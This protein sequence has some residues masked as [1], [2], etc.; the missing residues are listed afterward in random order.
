MVS[1]ET[2]KA[3]LLD[4]RGRNVLRPISAPG[5]KP[6]RRL[7]ST[8]LPEPVFTSSSGAVR[9]EDGAATH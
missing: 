9:A 8:L 1:R 5:L 6:L 4:V 3:T 7:S 2:A